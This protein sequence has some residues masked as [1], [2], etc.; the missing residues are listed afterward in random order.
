MPELTEYAKQ[1]GA[2]FILVVVQSTAILLFKL[3]QEGGKYTFNP[4]S[5]VALTEICKLMLASSLHWYG[6][7]KSKKPFWEGVNTRVVLHYFGLSALY[8]FNNQLSFYAL[9]VADPGSMSLGKS[10][11]P[12]LCALLLRLTGQSLHSLQWV[13]VIV[14]CCAIAIV[15]YDAC[16]GMGYLPLKAYYMI[17]LATLITAVTSVWNQLIIKGFEVP[18]NLQNSIMY[19]FGSVIAIGSYF[20]SAT[21]K[22]LHHKSFFEGYT[23]LALLLVLFQAF[24]GLAVAL[25]YKYADAIVK[26]FANSSVM[27]ILIVIS[28]YFFSLQTTLHS[29]L[30]IVIVLTTTYC[31]M[32]IAIGLQA[33]AAGKAPKTLPEKAHLL[34]DGTDGTE[35]SNN[36]RETSRS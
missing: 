10:V 2:F 1:V 29:W 4:A 34:E 17:G 25:V 32:N 16:R 27:A 14:Q 23:T 11:A 26:N 19:A 3:C 9:E 8:T 20:H 6:L 36:G 33:E 12:Y 18:V 31:Y 22:P 21:S 13:C 35:T 24:H 7:S 5:S 30:G 28:A 15:Q